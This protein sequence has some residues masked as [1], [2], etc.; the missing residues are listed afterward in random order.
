MPGQRCTSSQ[1][2]QLT[3]V[4]R[5]TGTASVLCCCLMW[6]RVY[7]SDPGMITKDNLSFW[8]SA[9]PPG[10][11]VYPNRQCYTCELPRPARSKHCSLCDGCVAREDHHCAQL[12]A[13]AFHV[14]R[15]VAEAYQIVRMEQS[16]KRRS[17]ISRSRL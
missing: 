7:C 10:D 4:F 9:D 13:T 17:N 15:S 11:P 16:G 8:M 6:F 14:N 3:L 5:Y 2:P 12:S 1:L